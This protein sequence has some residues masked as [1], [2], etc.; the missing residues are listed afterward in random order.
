MK[1][2]LK[3][4]TLIS[5]VILFSA[6]GGGGGGAG[7][8]GPVASTNT[9][10]IQSGYQRLKSTGFSK[11]FNITGTCTGTLTITAAPATSATTFE[12]S[13]AL[14]GAEVVS[15]SW[16]N[17]TPATG[18]ATAVRYYDYNYVP[19]GYSTT[20]DYGL[21]LTPPSVPTT[22]RI[23][24]VVVVGSITKY[25]SS[26]KT[27]PNGREDIT[28]AM[29][30][31]TATTAIANIISKTYNA[32]GTLLWTEQDRYRVAADGSLTPLSLDIQYANGST[33]HLVGN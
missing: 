28:L 20:G 22:A 21:Y 11:T 18:S 13:S 10:N 9:F 4:A 23:N 6:C 12:G 32:S 8:N 30:A 3:K 27:T 17:C 7:N 24:D 14:S 5:S 33:T 26:A 15:T 25:T 1:T 31:D 16:T 2:Y 29:E 19:R